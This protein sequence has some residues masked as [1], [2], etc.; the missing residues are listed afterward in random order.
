VA[1]PSSC[2]RVPGGGALP[3][4]VQGVVP[5]H[6]RG[7]GCGTPQELDGEHDSPEVHREVEALVCSR[8]HDADAATV[9]STASAGLHPGV[10]DSDPGCRPPAQIELC[11]DGVA[12]GL[13][14]GLGTD[15]QPRRPW[16]H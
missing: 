2:V 8:P 3:G 1:A 14:V 5:G 6:D 11:L 12:A 10:A 9:A 16:A 7:D 15:E 13:T 4:A